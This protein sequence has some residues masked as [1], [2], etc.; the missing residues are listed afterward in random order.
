MSDP[1]ARLSLVRRDPGAGAPLSGR[2]DDELMLLARGGMAGA[3]AALVR[4]HQARVLRVAARRLGRGA[5]A[6]DVAQNTF[7]EI[8]RA[9]PRYQPRGRFRS[10]LFRVLL[11][12][13]GMARRAAHLDA[14][15]VAAALAPPAA[16]P[17]TQEAEILARERGR[18][19]EAAL[20]RLG[21]K[22]RDVVLLRF[23]AELSYDE[24]AETLAVPVG[25][26][27]RRLFDA[28]EKLRRLM[29]EA[30]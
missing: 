2:E 8:Y 20:A 6:A 3:F 16:A 15:A 17:P 24:I 10:Y 11:N 30:P 5:L 4:R 9:L 28:M 18:D 14:R 22:L 26:V 29:E 7:L 19:V 21:S 13:C 27:K 25:T 12:Q 23:S 1:G